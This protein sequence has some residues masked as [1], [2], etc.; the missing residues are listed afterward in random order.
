M[1]ANASDAGATLR[2]DV[3]EVQIAFAVSDA[4][5]HTVGALRSSD[6]AVVDNGSII[7]H[8]RSFHPASETPLDLVLLLDASGSM[9]PQLAA[10]IADAKAFIASTSWHPRDRVSIL[11]FGGTEPQILCA[12]NCLA[13]HEVHKLDML[14]A[15]GL[16][17]LFD[18]LLQAIE[19]LGRDRDPEMRPA[20]VVISDG[21]DTFSIHSLTEAAEAAQDLQ[22]PIYT[23]NP[24]PRGSGTVEGDEI[25]TQLASSTGGLNFL[26]ERNLQAVLRAVLG[27]L[28]SGYVL[29]YDLPP[30]RTGEHSVQL[31]PTTDPRLH[32][33]S[34]Q[35]Y[36]D[37][38]Y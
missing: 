11:S 26:L 17:P 6:V 14:R 35:G 19:I 18:A 25:L 5:G 8:F 33:R 36:D 23:V 12:R 24:R 34:R 37:S 21:L 30:M 9:Q 3:N 29:T 13:G 32:F 27:D 20:M 4:K 22:V 7:R 16:T 2:A 28:H 38:E 15:N 31:L 1:C 10:E